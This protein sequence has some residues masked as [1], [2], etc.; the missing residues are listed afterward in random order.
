MTKNVK[1][2][3]IV[4]S[5]ILV[6]TLIIVF[7]L[8]MSSKKNNEIQ[9]VSSSNLFQ[10]TDFNIKNRTVL[11]KDNAIYVGNNT[12]ELQNNFC[13][14]KIQNTDNGVAID[15]NKLWYK[16]YGDDYIQ[17]DYL[18][19]ICREITNRLNVKGDSEQIEYAMYQYIKDN[20]IKVRES[21]TVEDIL[22]D[23]INMKLVLEEQ[24]VKLIIRGS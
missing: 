18:A 23:E 6:A 21:E 14:I 3:I 1:K 7:I 16:T 8:N 5:I 22:T 20:Y 12:K 24:I 13:D 2:I 9:Q 4:V 19:Q 10:I 15:L 17:D 11:K